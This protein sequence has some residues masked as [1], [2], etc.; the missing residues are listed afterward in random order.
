MLC[1]P[2]LWV[3]KFTQTRQ[4]FLQITMKSSTIWASMDLSAFWCFLS[5]SN[6]YF[7]LSVSS[8]RY[9]YSVVW[10]SMRTE[11]ETYILIL[12]N[13]IMPMKTHIHARTCTHT[14]I[15]SKNGHNFFLL[16]EQSRYLRL[17]IEE[18]KNAIK[19]VLLTVE[20]QHTILKFNASLWGIFSFLF[21]N[22]FHGINQVIILLSFNPPFYTDQLVTICVLSQKIW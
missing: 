5:Y 17:R 21:I 12:R 9:L 18:K 19:C 16:T 7:T 2:F 10:S 13:I 3:Y 15:F 1:F 14:Q 6:P 11:R 20:N 22:M 8:W 4:N